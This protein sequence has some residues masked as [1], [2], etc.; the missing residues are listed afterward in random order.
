MAC[1]DDLFG[2][3]RAV[4]SSIRPGERV[5]RAV[6]KIWPRHHY[7]HHHLEDWGRSVEVTC[8]LVAIPILGFITGLRPPTLALARGGKGRE[9]PPSGSV[10][11]AFLLQ[12]TYF[13]VFGGG[14]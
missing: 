1:W 6:I 2:G 4:A 12:P 3:R 8:L 10:D 9:E 14:A 5:G 7:C 13:L 11:E